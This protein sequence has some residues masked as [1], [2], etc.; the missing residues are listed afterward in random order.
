MKK[1]IGV[2]IL[3]LVVGFVIISS[4]FNKG[5]TSDV[6]QAAIKKVQMYETKNTSALVIHG[7]Q[8]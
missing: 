4:M 6:K 1:V 2:V 5:S 8:S 7:E 3:G